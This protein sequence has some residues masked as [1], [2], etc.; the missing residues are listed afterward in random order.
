M[1]LSHRQNDAR[2]TQQIAQDLRKRGDDRACQDD[3]FSPRADCFQRG[4]E[5]ITKFSWRVAA[6]KVVDTYRRVASQGVPDVSMAESSSAD[7]SR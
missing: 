1:G 3:P 6:T 4:S 2:S 7:Y 5:Q